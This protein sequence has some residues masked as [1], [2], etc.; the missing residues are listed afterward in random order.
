MIKSKRDAIKELCNTIVIT[1]QCKQKDGQAANICIT[2]QS[3]NIQNL[4]LEEIITNLWIHLNHTCEH[5]WL[6]TVSVVSRDKLQECRQQRRACLRRSESRVR[7][8][9]PAASSIWSQSCLSC[10]LL[11]LSVA[12]TTTI[13]ASG[14][15]KLAL[16]CRNASCTFSEHFV[17]NKHHSV[18]WSVKWATNNNYFMNS[19]FT[20]TWIL[21]IPVT[22]RASSL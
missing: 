5:T 17:S 21:N 14:E 7:T 2:T 15:S 18:L 1:D 12:S 4:R 22:G 19:F 10:S 9:Q 6:I 8:L 16:I 20:C 13:P 11:L 3:K